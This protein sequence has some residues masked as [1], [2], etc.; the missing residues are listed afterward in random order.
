MVFS[1]FPGYFCFVSFSFAMTMAMGTIV[2]LRGKGSGA[3]QENWVERNTCFELFDRVLI[4]CNLIEPL[5]YEVPITDI[6]DTL[7]TSELL[8]I[9]EIILSIE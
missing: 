7:S 1:F 6:S 3:K 9:E 8:E 2:I 4:V 5:K